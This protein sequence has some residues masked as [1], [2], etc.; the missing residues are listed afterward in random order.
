M[1]TNLATL[2][3]VQDFQQALQAGAEQI[4]LL[5]CSYDLLDA[6]RGQQLYQQGHLDGA[7][8]VDLHRDLAAPRSAKSSRHPL[9]SKEQFIQCLR[10]LGVHQDSW[11]IAYDNA[12]G[13]YAARLWWMLGWVG[14]SKRSVLDG[15]IQAW[16]Q[17]GLAINAEA[18]PTPA[19]GD[20]SLRPSLQ[21]ML[22]YQAVYQDLG[23][24]K[25]QL[26]DARNAE[27]FRG[28]NE[29]MDS[30]AGHIPGAKNRFFMQNLDEQGFFKTPEQLREEWLELLANR[31]ADQIV[32]Q[33][34]SG[35]TACHNLLA[36][37]LSGL[38]GSLLYPGSWSEWSQY[39]E[40]PVAV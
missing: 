34:G 25:W 2:L 40:A 7:L 38:S 12:H 5:D 39:D 32:H 28:Q 4:V 37:E 11:V 31:P 17:A 15:Y 36:L 27:R 19:A 24:G 13:M 6:E 33:C 3:R 23:V 14:H 16:Q 18:V 22:D 30:K 35:V 26:I 29:T 21:K 10:Q 9:P 8:Y 1:S 20:I